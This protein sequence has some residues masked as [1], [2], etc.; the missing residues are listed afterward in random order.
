MKR[1]TFLSP[2]H[3]LALFLSV[4]GL[5]LASLRW[6]GTTL[7]LPASEIAL[8]R[9]NSMEWDP[10]TGTL[11]RTGVDPYAW[12]PLP[13]RIVPLEEVVLEFSGAF[14]TDPWPFFIYHY[15]FYLPG[16]DVSESRLAIG[17]VQR[18]AER[19]RVRWTL[20][21][22]KMVRLD[23]PDNLETPLSVETISFRGRFVSTEDP[24]FVLMSLAFAA[25]LALTI[26]P[27]LQTILRRRPLLVVL[28]ITPLVALKVVIARD[29]PFQFL[30]DA[31]HDDALFIKQAA[32]IMDGQWLGPFNSLTLSKGPFYPIFLALTGWSGISLKVT[33]AV[34]HAAACLAF[35]AALRPLVPGLGWRAVLLVALLFEPNSLSATALGRI[36]R[37]GIHPA[38]TLFTLA[39]SIGL[40]LN[41][42][43]SPRKAIGWAIMAGVAGTAFWLSREEGIWLAPSLALILGAGAVVALRIRD[44]RR[45]ARLAILPIPLALVFLGTWGL[46]LVNEHFYGAPISIDVRDGN[47]PAAYGALLRIT[48]TDFVPMVPVTQA[49]R[50]RA[51]AVSPAFA[52]MQRLLEGRVGT[53][54]SQHGWEGVDHPLAKKDIRGGW[55]PWALR[56]AAEELGYY[57]NAAAADAYWARVAEEIN[58]ACES[59]QL[60]SS[61]P[62]RGFFP[63][64]K[65]SYW[66]PF[67]RSAINGSLHVIEVRDFYTYLGPD[68]GTPQQLAPFL[69]ITHE[70]GSHLQQSPS[71]ATHVSIVAHHLVKWIGTPATLFAAVV[72]VLLALRS[73]RQPQ[74]ALPLTT[75]LA[76][77]G[78]AAA[79]VVVV[80]LVDITSF[81]AIQAIY[82]APATPLVVAAWI[83]AAAWVRPALIL[84][85]PSTIASQQ[86]S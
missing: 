59:G 1:L 73:V 3:Q 79:L 69:Q 62:R 7:R 70:S 52:E 10:A 81:H 9:V 35:V 50:L 24:V 78:G 84:S 63:T 11:V 8:E 61:S 51:Y 85:V 37:S 77:L 44:S 86:P 4:V 39:G 80:A 47:F 60:A 34:L 36:L 26:W 54:W 28:A 56:Q 15:P 49:T 21:S 16:E 64:W 33:Q 48:P 55:F 5:G 74:M 42:G 40:L 41:L 58:T 29:I 82:L 23:L 57:R 32:A 20:P 68:R 72:T 76:L 43:S 30:G 19:T 75:L 38:L 2:L 14:P 31:G 71:A 18:S 83:L 13:A 53:G 6:H 45:F 46:R 17:E 66:P 22:S 12:I 65:A 25:A 27:P 67:F